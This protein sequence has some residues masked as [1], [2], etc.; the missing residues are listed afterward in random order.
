MV[1][2]AKLPLSTIVANRGMKAPSA[3]LVKIEKI[4]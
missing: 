2:Q 1:Y 4:S 3:F